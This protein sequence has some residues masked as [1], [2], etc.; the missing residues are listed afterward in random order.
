MV[1][2]V[3]C[4]VTDHDPSDVAPSSH[5]VDDLGIDSLQ[6]LEVGTIVIEKYGID[7]V[8]EDLS[9]LH[10]VRDLVELFESRQ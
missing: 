5:L 4:E 7:L 6:I 3:I 8:E 1:A 9:G 10:T 2:D